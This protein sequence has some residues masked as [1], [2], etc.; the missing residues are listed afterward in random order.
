MQY[1]T[2]DRWISTVHRVVNPPRDK[3]LGSRR[4][5]LVFF[6]TPNDDALIS[7]LETCQSADNPPKYAPVLAGEHLRRKSAQAGTLADPP[8]M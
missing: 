3:S 8:K 6:H 2:N 7:C 1:W 5:S 4:Q